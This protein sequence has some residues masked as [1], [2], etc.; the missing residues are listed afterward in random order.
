[1]SAEHQRTVA[2]RIVKEVLEEQR[3]EVIPEL[4][5]PHF[6]SHDWGPQYAEGLKGIR[7]L[8]DFSKQAFVNVKTEMLLDPIVDGDMTVSFFT[9]HAEHKGDLWGQPSTG[10]SFTERIVHILRFEDGKV[11]EHWR[12]QNDLGMLK[13]L[14]VWPENL[15]FRNL[16]VDRDDPRGSH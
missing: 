16:A 15:V 10:R 6:R 4:F 2:R 8:I 12:V 14:G 1:M 3:P 11:A 13:Q 7:Q 5:A 9:Y